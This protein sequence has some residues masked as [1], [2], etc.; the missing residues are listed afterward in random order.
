M[1]SIVICG[2][3]LLWG[4]YIQTIN[5]GNS[6]IASLRKM[7]AGG[8]S[9]AV[10]NQYAQK[11]GLSLNWVEASSIG[12][13]HQRMFV[14]RLTL[15]ERLTEGRGSN[16]KLAKEDAAKRMMEELHGDGYLQTDSVQAQRN[17]I[18]V[19]QELCQ[20]S[21]RPIPRYHEIS[22]VG[23]SNDPTFTFAV[24]IHHP[25]TGDEMNTQGI[26]KSKDKAKFDA[27]SAMLQLLESHESCEYGTSDSGHTNPV[28]EPSPQHMFPQ[29]YTTSE[30]ASRLS[31]MGPMLIS[32]SS[33]EGVQCDQQPVPKPRT[34]PPNT[35]PLVVQDIS[36]ISSSPTL[37]PR[38][39]A[40]DHYS[41]D[42]LPPHLP[43][44]PS[45]APS[46]CLTT[47]MQP[48]T[49]TA[50]ELLPPRSYG[51]PTVLPDGNAVPP[52]LGTNMLNPLQGHDSRPSDLVPSTS[53][54]TPPPAGRHHLHPLHTTTDRMRHCVSSDLPNLPD[55]PSFDTNPQTM[56]TVQST[57]ASEAVRPI[58][59]PRKSKPGTS[60]VQDTGRESGL[61]VRAEDKQSDHGDEKVV[62]VPPT[63]ADT[64]AAQ[65]LQHPAVCVARADSGPCISEIPDTVYNPLEFVRQHTIHLGTLKVVPLE[66]RDQRDRHVCFLSLSQ[67][68]G[69]GAMTALGA[70]PNAPEAE[71]DAAR[72]LWRQLTGQGKI[73]R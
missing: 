51:I 30:E 50:Q 65:P 32:R 35:G 3:L 61:A 25:S 56:L 17:K 38:G 24:F 43:T 18:S 52:D 49:C 59:K 14:L 36:T 66:G 27:A 15:G 48:P 68:E 67:V 69:L 10:V 62:I 20:K 63:Q 60:A 11:H 55:L 16:K 6:P 19:L 70:G 21:G 13:P 64:H 9:V 44:V 7:A 2:V 46:M 57:K 34:R 73:V 45:A 12:P 28:W 4:V 26:G 41:R 53:S 39:S 71:Q 37:L 58:P 42:M 40:Q 54:T 22:R 29:M 31:R 47:P 5:V 1:H 72:C 8:S 23:P 33:S